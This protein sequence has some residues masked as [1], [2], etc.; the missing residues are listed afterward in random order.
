MTRQMRRGKVGA[1]ERALVLGVGG[2][3]VGPDRLG[4]GVFGR[5]RANE[6]GRRRRDSSDVCGGGGDTRL[7]AQFAGR[8]R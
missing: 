8:E 1:R 7:H 4:G 3:D 6:T 5:F 2:V